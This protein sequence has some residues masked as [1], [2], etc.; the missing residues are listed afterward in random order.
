MGY[1]RISQIAEGKN[2]P[3]LNEDE[4]VVKTLAAGGG[5]GSGSGE[6]VVG[7]KLY[8]LL[9]NQSPMTA[10]VTATELGQN[11]IVFV[12]PDNPVWGFINGY[13]KIANDYFKSVTIDGVTY[14]MQGSGSSSPNGM[15]YAN[16]EKFGS[17]RITSSGRKFT[18]TEKEGGSSFT[19][20]TTASVTSLKVELVKIPRDYS[21]AFQVSSDTELQSFVDLVWDQA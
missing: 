15:L 13:S 7:K 11:Q 18:I 14:E 8:D 3:A 16:G 1:T 20:G 12:F 19:P 10:T 21:V 2:I 4:K 5:G 17:W 6:T 9:S